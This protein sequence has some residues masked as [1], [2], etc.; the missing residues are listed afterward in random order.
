[1]TEM[2]RRGFLNT[3]GALAAGH[4]L[5]APTATRAAA[6]GGALGIGIVGVGNRGSVLLQN[7][8]AIPGV[9]PWSV[10]YLAVR[11]STDRDAFTAGDLVLRRA[12][13]QVDA[14]SALARAEAWR[15]YRAYALFH[16]WVAAAYL[17]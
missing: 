9:G 7:L 15:P 12:L 2:N 1:M 11:S 10:D 5:A 6:P 16:L 3:T 13:G 17:A 8:L 14:R 4:V